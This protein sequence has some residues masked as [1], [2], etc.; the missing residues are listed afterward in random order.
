MARRHCRDGKGDRDG[1]GDVY[2]DG[3]RWRY[4]DEMEILR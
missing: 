1:E 2:V 3:R 4:L